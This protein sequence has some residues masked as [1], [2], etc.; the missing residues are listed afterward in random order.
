MEIDITQPA[1]DSIDQELFSLMTSL[2]S[3]G[4]T[5]MDCVEWYQFGL[6]QNQLFRLEQF[7]D[8]VDPIA[9]ENTRFRHDWGDLYPPTLKIEKEQAWNLV[10]AG[11]AMFDLLEESEQNRIIKLFNSAW[12]HHQE[13]TNDLNQGSPCF[14]FD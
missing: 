6:E 10:L 1:F 3:Q 2:K 12:E 14:D 7:L 9:E 11:C 8:L 5:Y 4:L 13:F